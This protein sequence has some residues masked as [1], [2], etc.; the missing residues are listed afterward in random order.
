MR[1]EACGEKTDVKE[2][3]TFV[4]EKMEMYYVE[5]RHQ[6]KDCDHRFTTIEVPRNVWQKTLRG[7]S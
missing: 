2:T 7:G 5:R 3:R 6:C 4:D 1:C